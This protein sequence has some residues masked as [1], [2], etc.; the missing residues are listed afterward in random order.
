MSK[1]AHGGSNAA[2]GVDWKRARGRHRDRCLGGKTVCRRVRQGERL[3]LWM[4]DDGDGMDGFIVKLRTCGASKSAA[5]PVCA[6]ISVIVRA[7]TL[8]HTYIGTRK[9]QKIDAVSFWGVSLVVAVACS[10]GGGRKGR[11]GGG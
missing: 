7:L 4:V 11:G 5:W 10:K 2:T 3:W 1:E 8:S 9:F 6:E